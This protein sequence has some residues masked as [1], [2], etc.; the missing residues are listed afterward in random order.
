MSRLPVQYITNAPAQSG[1]GHQAQEI[2]RRL[3]ASGQVDLMRLH[4]DG[5]SGKLLRDGQETGSIRP[6]PGV[7]GSKSVNWV[8]L[9]HKL[10]RQISHPLPTPTPSD[11]PS[12]R[13]RTARQGEKIWHLT[14]QTLSFLAKKLQPAVVT[15]H[16]II[17]L[18]EPQ[19]KKAYW[20]NRYLYSGIPAASHIIAVSEYTK[21]TVQEYFDIPDEKITVV[22]NGVGSEFHP[23]ENFEQTVAYHD[24]R[25]ELKLPDTAQVVLYVGSDHPRKNVVAAVRAFAKAREA[26][27]ATHEL[28]FIKV[29]AA[30]LPAGRAELLEEIDELKIRESVRILDSVSPTRLNEL[31]NLAAV[32]IYPSRF[33][34]FG[35][36]PLQA[37]AA[38]TPVITSNTTSLPEVV[39][40]AALTH[41]PDDVDGFAASM[42]AILSD[43]ILAEGLRQKGFARAGLFS[44]DIAAQKVLG[45]YQSLSS[46]G[47]KE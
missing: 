10:V 43:Q 33:E 32:F 46:G 40:D 16:D 28:A 20:L 4:I 5:E 39:G 26:L 23:I 18:L 6:W 17:E 24:L 11:S 15:V 38:G 8:R 3:K 1:V 42:V 30:G 2:E 36:P 41:G 25:H 14:N 44:W 29:G 34:G 7:L 22:H 9:G 37:M 21:K 12:G 13:G 45:V 47:N 27:G 31:Y 35:L 19:D